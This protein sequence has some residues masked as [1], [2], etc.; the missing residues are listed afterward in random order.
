MIAGFFNCYLFSEHK[1]AIKLVY[2]NTLLFLSVPLNQS[3]N[4]LIFGSLTDQHLE[5]REP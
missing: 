5:N 3:A 2:I 1:P 4:T